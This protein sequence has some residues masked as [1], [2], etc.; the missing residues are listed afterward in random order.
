VFESPGLAEPRSRWLGPALVSGAVR[1]EV[2]K[3]DRPRIEGTALDLRRL[4]YRRDVSIGNF[5]VWTR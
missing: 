3:T 1:E 4:G 5:F 2:S